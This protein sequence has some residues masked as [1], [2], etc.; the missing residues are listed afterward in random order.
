VTSLPSEELFT[1]RR[2]VV[3]GAPRLQLI[4]E[5]D[6][7]TVSTLR[8][9]IARELGEHRHPLVLDCAEL[10]F[11]DGS[12]L[13]VVEWAA[14]VFTP[15]RVEL[16]DAS[17]AVRRLAALTGLDRVVDFVPRLPAVHLHAV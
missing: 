7:W 11:I 4:G 17:P 1:V 2:S 5:L 10:R 15:R 12:G 9:A 14:V 3:A 6:A 16:H 13:R 8:D